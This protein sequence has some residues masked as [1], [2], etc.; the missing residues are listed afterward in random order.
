[1]YKGITAFRDQQD[2]RGKMIVS[3]MPFNTNIKITKNDCPKDYLMITIFFPYML[4]YCL[5]SKGSCYLA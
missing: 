4:A 2:V 1:M 5:K 3:L